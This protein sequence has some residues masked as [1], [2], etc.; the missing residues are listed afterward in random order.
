[1][2][3]EGNILFN[4][5]FLVVL[6]ICCCCEKFE[7]VVVYLKYFYRYFNLVNNNKGVCY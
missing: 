6:Y 5:Y 2:N 4:V 3:S 7:I 1:M